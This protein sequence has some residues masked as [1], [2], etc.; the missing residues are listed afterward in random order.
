MLTPEQIALVEDEITGSGTGTYGQALRAV[1][2][3][4]KRAEA[5]AA[6]LRAIVQCADDAGIPPQSPKMRIVHRAFIEAA[7]ALLEAK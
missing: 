6:Q 2:A 4:A 3:E 5:L 1:L 7:R